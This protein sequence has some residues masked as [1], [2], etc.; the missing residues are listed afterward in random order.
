MFYVSLSR[1]K[2]LL[3]IPHYK[4]SGQH[5]SPPFDEMLKEEITRIPD[6]NVD[7]LPAADKDKHQ[8]GKTYSY[9]GDYLVYKKCPRQYMVFKKYGFVPS[10]S[11][12]MFFGTL[13]HQTIED[14]H[15]LF[16][17]RRP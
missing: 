5:T 6:F 3:V 16:M 11:Q 2:N 7:T 4:G 14:L 8:L 1:P 17:Q 15:H 9:T 13:V 10:R 12:T